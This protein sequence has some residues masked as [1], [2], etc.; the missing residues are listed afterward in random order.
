[1]TPGT[2]H[3]TGKLR[4]DLLPPEAIRALAQVLTHGAAKYAPNNWR[5][6]EP[7]RYEAALLRH[8]LAWKEGEALDPEGGLPDLARVWCNAAFLGARE[9]GQ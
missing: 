3:D 5:C 1:M 4:L 2:K 8:W 7:M 6:V 9:G